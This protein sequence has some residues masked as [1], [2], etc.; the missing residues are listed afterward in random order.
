M[1]GYPQNVT[2]TLCTL[3]PHMDCRRFKDNHLSFLDDAL[4]AVETVVMQRHLAECERCARHDIAVRRGLMVFRNLPTI[5]L[6]SGFSERL[7]ARLRETTALDRLR[8][9]AERPH[10]APGL[11]MFAATATG[12][13]AASLLAVTT[14]DWNKP[15]SDLA[16]PPVIATMPA[17]D[18]NPMADPA[19]VASVS[20]GMPVWPAALLVEEAPS[21]FMRSQFQFASYSR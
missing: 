4:P 2:P 10:R 15:A 20:A 8:A 18:P 9:A 6:S 12:L 3:A 13:L 14:L 16:L 1:P 11:G 7:N 19:I 17:Q 21:H 5:E